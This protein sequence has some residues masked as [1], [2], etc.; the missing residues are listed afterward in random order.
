[1]VFFLSHQIII[2]RQ[3]NK[4]GLR[5]AFS[6][7]GTVQ[8]LDL[9]PVEIE[10]VNLVGGRIGKTYEGWLDASI[11]IKEGDQVK[12]VD[13]GQIFTVKTVSTFEGAGLLDHH[14]LILIAQD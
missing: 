7:T 2:R 12:I 11:N 1:M 5:F 14:S 6:A 4:S 8:D 9:Q 10:R 13:T 3:R